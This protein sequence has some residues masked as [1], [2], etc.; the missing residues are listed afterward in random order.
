MKINDVEKKQY[1]SCF[2]WKVAFQT[3]S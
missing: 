3:G 1:T 2:V